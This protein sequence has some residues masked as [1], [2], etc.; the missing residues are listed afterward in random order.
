MERKNYL[1][2]RQGEETLPLGFQAVRNKGKQ[3]PDRYPISVLSDRFEE[4]GS[5]SLPSSWSTRF[6]TLGVVPRGSP[7]ARPFTR[8]SLHQ[9]RQSE[10]VHGI[11]PVCAMSRST[12]QGGRFEPR[13]PLRASFPSLGCICRGASDHPQGHP[14]PKSGSGNGTPGR[15]TLLGLPRRHRRMSDVDAVPFNPFSDDRGHLPQSL[16]R[17]LGDLVGC[18][19]EFT[20]RRDDGNS[21]QHTHS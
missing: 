10:H 6:R 5:I 1:A 15:Y 16:K 12:D 20:F 14:P 17:V 3:A 11:F 19:S 13:P 4:R 18:V 7:H 9:T 21:K 2:P 8:P